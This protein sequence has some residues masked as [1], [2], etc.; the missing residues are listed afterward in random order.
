VT[1]KAAACGNLLL[2]VDGENAWKGVTALSV[3][4]EL[5][6]VQVERAGARMELRM[7]EL[8]TASPSDGGHDYED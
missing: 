7:F 6:A 3:T 2:V 4:A 5:S 8:A 1:G